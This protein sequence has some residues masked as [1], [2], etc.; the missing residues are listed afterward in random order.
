MEG[1]LCRKKLKVCDGA[2][3]C[4][5]KEVGFTGTQMTSAA[6]GGC[7]KDTAASRSSPESVSV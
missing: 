5:R 1:F 4:G 2:C 7:V 3:M 6:E